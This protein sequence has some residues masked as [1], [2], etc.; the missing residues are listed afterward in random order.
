MSRPTWAECRSALACVAHPDPHR[1]AALG[2]RET[3]LGERRQPERRRR[4]VRKAETLFRRGQRTVELPVAILAMIDR[5]S[6][7][8]RRHPEA[9]RG[10][11]K[12]TRLNSSTYGASLLPHAA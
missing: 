8:A 7:M 3:H 6:I 5:D 11:R 1:R 4:V 10:D 9:R 2:H 12:T